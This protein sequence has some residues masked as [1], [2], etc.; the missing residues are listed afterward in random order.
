[1]LD[2]LIWNTDTNLRITSLSARL[3]DFAG[4]GSRGVGTLYAGDLWG[5]SSAIGLPIVGHYWALA[6]ESVGFDAVVDGVTLRFDLEPLTNPDG[7][8]AGVAGRATPLHGNAHLTP[9]TIAAAERTAGVGTWYED[10]ASGRVSISDGLGTLLGVGTGVTVLDIRAFD[11][12]DE[13]AS[14]AREIAELQRDGLSYSHDHRI[15]R[16]DSQVRNVR[17]RVRTLV[18]ERA[19]PYARIGTLVD[20]TDFKEREA[21]LAELAHYDALTRLPNRAM[22]EE[23]LTAAIG[24]ARRNETH[25]AVLFIDLDN[26]KEINDRRGHAAGDEILTGVADRLQRNVRGSDMVARFGGDEFVVLLEDLYS[27]EAALDAARK[28]LRSFDEPLDLQR[29]SV[30]ISASIGICA[31][32]GGAVDAQAMLAAADAEM[33]AVKRNGGNGVKRAFVEKETPAPAVQLVACAPQSNKG[34]RH[35]ASVVNA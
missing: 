2:T 8:T 6:G 13:R 14:T 18:D 5:H 24:R 15:A 27:A 20:I 35:Y 4:I 25:C 32:P 1:M 12:P 3:R 29:S 19:M 10:L 17:E 34:S 28:L 16:F 21:H 33:Y 26:F 22:L 11:H 7:S 31:Y 9:D 30:R 23:R